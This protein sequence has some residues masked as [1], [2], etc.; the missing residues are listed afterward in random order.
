[1]IYILLVLKKFHVFL[2]ILQ[3]SNFTVLFF[4][5]MK[6][7]INQSKSNQFI[8][9]LQIIFGIIKN[10]KHRKEPLIKYKRGID[11]KS[12]TQL[13]YH[14]APTSETQTRSTPRLGAVLVSIVSDVK[15]WWFSVRT[16]LR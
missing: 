11:L 14:Q 16:I 5:S 10:L 7:P 8:L 6:S 9:Y 1:M 12:M 3:F 4:V 2:F 13:R 15:N